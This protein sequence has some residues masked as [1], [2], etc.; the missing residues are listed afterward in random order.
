[1]ANISQFTSDLGNLLNTLDDPPNTRF[2]NGISNRDNQ[3][4]T[5]RLPNGSSV[6]MYINPENFSVAESKL[7]TPTRTKGGFVVQYWGDN[8]NIEWNYWL[9]R[10]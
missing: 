5:W 9:F 6:Q 3:V 1:M 2:A 7:I 10:C 8:N 4:M